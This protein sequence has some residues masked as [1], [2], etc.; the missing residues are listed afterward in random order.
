MATCIT[1][2]HFPWKRDP[3]LL[4]HLPVM[5]CHPSLPARRFTREGSL[6]AHD[7]AVYEPI[8][9]VE[10]GEA[11]TDGTTELQTG[12]DEEKAGGQEPQSS[13]TEDGEEQVSGQESPGSQTGDGEPERATETDTNA[14]QVS[15]LN[16]EQLRERAR[17]L[18]I[19]GVATLRRADLIAA[20]Q[21]AEAEASVGGNA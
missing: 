4:L 10:A 9:G 6:A 7:C 1:C 11:T 16:V 18:G 3:E 20:I 5:A 14:D 21:T 17:A 15:Q 2:R 19:K 13:Q 12:D 8:G